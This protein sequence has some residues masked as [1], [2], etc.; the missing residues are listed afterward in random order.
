MALEQ[1]IES[2][3]KHHA[4]ID[5][6]LHEEQMRPAPDDIRLHNLKC[7]KLFVKD[8]LNRLLHD[9]QEAA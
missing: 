3:K 1:R 9:R 7:Q 4:Q 5:Q 6:A 8:E 2:L